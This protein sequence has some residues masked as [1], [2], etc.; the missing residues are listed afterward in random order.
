MS[1]FS[2]LNETDVGPIVAFGELLWDMLPTGAVL[3]GAPANFVYRSFSLGQ[4]AYLVS[5]LGNDKYGDDALIALQTLG[6]DTRFIQR[7]NFPT[8]TVAVTL[9]DNGDASYD[10][11]RGTAYDKIEIT[12][13]LLALVQ[14]CSYLCFGT[15][16]QRD[17]VSRATLGALVA[18]CRGKIVCDINLRR[19]CFSPEAICWSL[20]RAN[21]LKLN[22]DEVTVVKSVLN[23]PGDGI[24]EFVAHL[25]T[26]YPKLEECLVTMG[27]RGAAAFDRTGAKHEARG[28]Q[29]KVADTVG[30]GD[31]FTAGY[32]DARLKGRDIL[33]ALTLANQ[34]GAL[35]ATVRGGMSQIDLGKIYEL[36]P[37]VDVSFG[38]WGDQPAPRQLQL[39]QP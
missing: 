15:L 28:Y 17:A 38:R 37:A 16:G 30:S 20:E 31:S 36:I 19:D 25:M 6:F 12:E 21:V 11:Q 7:N 32:L 24:E 27:A 4:K 1:K 33:E 22:D 8:G 3:G 2:F 9:A 18:N 13:G 39:P 29:V 10:F 23:F 26:A 34:I 5:A 14:S 35:V